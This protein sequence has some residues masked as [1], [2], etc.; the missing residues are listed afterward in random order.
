MARQKRRP[1]QILRIIFTVS[2]TVPQKCQQLQCTAKVY[3]P[4]AS[5]PPT[6]PAL[7]AFMLPCKQF[8]NNNFLHLSPM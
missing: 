2:P 5:Q 7:Q 4:P 1:R 3:I 6:N 8:Q